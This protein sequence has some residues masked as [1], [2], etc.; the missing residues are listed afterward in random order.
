[1]SLSA[2]ADTCRQLWTL[3]DFLGGVCGEGLGSS[4]WVCDPMGP[5]GTFF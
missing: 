5:Q 4:P 3:A 1:M 2:H